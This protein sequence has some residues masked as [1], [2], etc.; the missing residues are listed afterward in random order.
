MH[1]YDFLYVIIIIIK[2]VVV[3]RNVIEFDLRLPLRL[4]Y[5]VTARA[6]K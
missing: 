2:I 4:Y 6:T 3:N 1:I 5:C